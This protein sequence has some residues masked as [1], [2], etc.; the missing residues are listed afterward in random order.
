[1]LLVRG[2]RESSSTVVGVT[3]AEVLLE[4]VHGSTARLL[5]TLRGLSDRDLRQ[6]SLLQGWSRAHVAGHLARNAD[7]LLNLVRWAKT[8]ES[9]P[10]YASGAHRQAGITATAALNHEELCQDVADSAERLSLAMREVTG[11]QWNRPIHWRHERNLGRAVGIP[12]MRWVEV[13]V[14]HVDLR[15]GYSFQ[16]W[17]TDFVQDMLVRVIEDREVKGNA[18]P[19]TLMTD[20]GTTLPMEGGGP[21]L[22]GPAWL[23]VAWLLGR[24]EIQGAPNL[25]PWR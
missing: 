1:M 24:A 7:G 10:M 14:H 23:L 19:A 2:A 17:P 4:S 20:D 16:D 5:S 3:S 21:Q 18:L 22:G 6:D 11:D 25:P 12:F 15:A 9:H 8:G 13:E